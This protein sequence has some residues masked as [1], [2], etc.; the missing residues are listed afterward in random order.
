MGEYCELH[1][2]E[3]FTG[4]VVTLAV[5]GK[6]RLRF[7]ARTRLQVGLAKIARLKLAPGQTVSISVP[8]L[9]LCAEYRVAEGDCWL[10][11]NMVDRALIVRTA[12][13]SPGYA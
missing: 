7:K 13:G 10:T 5:D 3:G 8:D 2:Q 9:G 6:M 4:D 1:F 12:Q 11:I